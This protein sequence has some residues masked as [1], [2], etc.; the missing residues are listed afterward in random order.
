MQEITQAKINFQFEFNSARENYMNFLKKYWFS[1]H[2]IHI[3]RW[4]VSDFMLYNTEYF[5]LVVP[6]K[7][8]R[9][10]SHKNTKE[11]GFFSLKIY[12][13]K[14]DHPHQD[15]HSDGTDLKRRND[16]NWKSLMVF[17][18]NKSHELIM[19][20]DSTFVWVFIQ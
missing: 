15:K 11:I 3:L 20:I 10:T 17:L 9:I 7:L 12:V 4:F 18:L 2:G 1:F 16:T 6:V 14:R 13:W 19:G 5:E 8:M